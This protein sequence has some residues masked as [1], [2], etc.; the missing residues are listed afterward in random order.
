MLRNVVGKVGAIEIARVL[1]AHLFGE[2]MQTWFPDFDR[3]AVRAHEHWLCPDHYDAESGHFDMPV[4]SWVFQLEGKTVLIDSCMGNG[5]NRPL[6]SEMHMLDTRYLDRLAAIG[7]QPAD[8]DYVM[9]THLHVDHVGWNTRLE[10][11][12]WVPTFPNARYVFNRIEYEATRATAEAGDG[13][14]FLR[15]VFED[16]ILPVVEA[17]RSDLVEDGHELLGCVRLNPAPGH[18]PG[19]V[20][21]ELRSLGHIGVFT[22]DLLHSPVQVPFW[23]WSS[24]V[25]WDKPMSARTRRDLLAFCASENAL[26]LSGHF[27]DPH[28]GRITARGDAFEIGF[29]W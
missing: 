16:S 17:G 19:H 13:A 11:G 24:R 14:P 15:H 25:C 3:D 9:C 21:I 4:H 10:N 26:L 1:D 20:R 27:V 8:V 12:R 28:V 5:K 6:L 29:G 22:G 2:T 7:I 18:S 23:Q